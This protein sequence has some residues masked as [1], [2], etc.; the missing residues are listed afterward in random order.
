MKIVFKESFLKDLKKIKDKTIKKRLEKVLQNLE[1]TSDLTSLNSI[2]KLSGH[3][4][5]Y[6]IRIGT[7]R[8]GFFY[9][10]NIIEIVVFTSRGNIYKNFP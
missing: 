8:L 6:R 9:E 5:A 1:T 3:S 7:Y 4:T 2:K 10:S